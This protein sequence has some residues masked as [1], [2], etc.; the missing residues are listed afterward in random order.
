M[1]QMVTRW[2]LPLSLSA[3][4]MLTGCQ[5]NNDEKQSDADEIDEVVGIEPG[6]GTMDIAENTIEEYSL[7]VQLTSS[8]E[9]AMLTGLKS[10]IEDEEPIVVT[11]WQP[12]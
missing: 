1:R 4:V 9:A 10:A 7:D 6:S 12:H 2:F 3:V 5:N 8:S 11:L